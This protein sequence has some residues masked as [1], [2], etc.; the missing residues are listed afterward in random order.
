MEPGSAES[1][2]SVDWWKL[3]SQ[4]VWWWEIE[5]RKKQMQLKNT[6][7]H[8]PSHFLSATSLPPWG[9]IAKKIHSEK[10]SGA[11]GWGV[12][13]R[14]NGPAYAKIKGLYQTVAPSIKKRWWNQKESFRSIISKSVEHWFPVWWLLD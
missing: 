12:A 3:E 9:T 7:S 1:W 11:E 5:T 13:L 14:P 2:G 8:P 6:F 10:Q 4:R